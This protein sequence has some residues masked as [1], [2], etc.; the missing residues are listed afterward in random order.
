MDATTGGIKSGVTWTVRRCIDGTFAAGGGTVTEDSTNGWYKYAMSQADSNGNNI[1]FNFTGTGAVPQTV[2][3]VTTAADPTDGVHFGLTSLPNAAA[4]ANTGL[5]VVG[6]QVPNATAGAAGGLWILGANAAAATTLTGTAGNNALTLTGGAASGATPAG[7]G[8]AM[9]GGAASTSSGGVAGRG[10]HATGGAGAASTNGAGDGTRSEGGGT[11]TVSGGAGMT[12]AH[13]GSANDLQAQTT[14]ALQVN[15]TAI[16]AV[17]TNGVTTVGAN[18][19]TTQ[20]LNFTGTG[21]SALVKSDMTDIAGAAVST[22]TAQLGVNV[23]QVN[24][25][26]TSNVTTI[27]ANQGTT[28]PVNFTGT[29]GSALVKS[30]MV[31]VAGSAVSTSSAQIGVNVVNIAG[32]AAALDANNLLKVDAEDWKGSAV[33]ALVNGWVPA[34]TPIRSGTAQAG[35]ASTI[36]LDAGASATNNLYDNELVY[37]AG[38]TGAGQVNT[39]SS[40]VG[41]TKVA[42]MISAWATNPDN[43]STFII[44]PAGPI[45]AT[46]SGGVNVTQW[47]GSAVA[48]PNIAGVPIVDVGDWLGHAVTVDTNN[49][50]NVSAKYLAG[51]SLTG[52]DIG[53]SVLLSAGTGTGQLDFTSGVV[54]ANATQWVGGTIPAVNVTGVPLVDLKYTLGT[55]SP[56]TAGY[57]APDWG[58]VNAPTTT[59]NLS[60]TTIS[61]SQAVASVSG[62]VGSVTAAVTLSAGDS[63]VFYSGTATAGG[64]TTLTDSGQTWTVNGLAG[65]AVKLTSGTGAHQARVVVSNTA[66]ALTVDRAWTTTPDATSVYTVLATDAPKT[67]SSLQVTAGSISGVTFPA[68]FSALGISAGGHISNVDTLTTYT[69]DTPQTGDSFVRI[70]ATGS[71]LTSLA[72]A[73]T[74]LSTAQW[75]NTLATN[76]GTLAGHDPGTTIGTSTLTQSQVT[77]GAY[78]LNSASFAFNA[79]MDFTA[80]EKTSLGTAVGTAQTGDTYALANGA[81]GFVAIKTDTAN[82]LTHLPAPIKKNTALSAF[83]FFMVQSSDH[84]TGATGLTVTAQR[85]LDGGAFGNCANAVVEVGSGVYKIDLA[86][87]DLNAGVVTLKMTATG[88]DARLITIVTQT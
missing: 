24:A 11:T 2:N 13:T 37:I 7:D 80:T 48:A 53:L 76:L 77:G 85:S 3:I 84:V 42:T 5:P 69:G 52:R 38:G 25:V 6:T 54:K 61:T 64:S 8:L 62:A 58:H 44:L 22:S 55:I 15:A 27:S 35:G 79:A 68:N 19:G 87:A 63:P 32:Q 45:S 81:N 28:Q 82:I 9:T 20:P 26:S 41:S 59:V 31:D 75:T 21:A 65:C 43:T 29:A 71:G 12:L 74:A 39:V 36:T 67:D 51:T 14:N 56:A 50:P 70:G 73:A 83:E 30:D 4:G 46:V 78:A 57:V 34:V 10:W 86:A 72:P 47:N 16:N 49:A 66:T 1:S 60:G 40:Y 18:V 17:S 23:V 88:A 33:T